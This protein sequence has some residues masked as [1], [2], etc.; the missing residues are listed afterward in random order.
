ME[1]AE[2]GDLMS[3]FIQ[4]CREE[5]T[6]VQE[7]DIWRACEAI[8][9]GLAALH[10]KNIIHRDIKPQNVLVM[11]DSTFKVS[12][13]AFNRSDR[14]HGHLQISCEQLQPLAVIFKGG[15]A[16]LHDSRADQATAV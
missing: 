8:S 15:H 3:Y 9:W 10:D 16:A 5:G 2:K 6:L 14:R 11:A 12:S 4:R 7:T 1:F 13:S